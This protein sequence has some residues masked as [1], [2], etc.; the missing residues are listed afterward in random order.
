MW[1]D[2][3]V[4]T[5][6]HLRGR[7][8]SHPDAED[9]AQEVLAAAYANIDGIDPSKL[10]AWLFAAARNK[11][12]DQH[13]RNRFASLDAV[14]SLADPG[15]NP[16]DATLRSLGVEA[17]RRAVGRLPE[18]DARLV[19]LHYF[20]ERS[21]AEI[22]CMQGMSATAVKVALFRARGRLRLALEEKENL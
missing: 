13:R 17:L 15:A 7:G 19:T 8:A 4:R 11:L 21:L 9:I 6:R 5:Y 22:A 12:V 18:R 2:L 16:E 10:Q 14:P 3:Y 20:E 1:R